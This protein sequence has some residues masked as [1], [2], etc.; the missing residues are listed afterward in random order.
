MRYHI[1]VIGQAR[2]PAF[3]TALPAPAFP[4]FDLADADVRLAW[5]E[6]GKS[7]KLGIP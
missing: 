5:A 6:R 3:L 1:I 2:A 4:P 7:G